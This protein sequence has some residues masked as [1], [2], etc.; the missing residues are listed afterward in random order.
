MD[1]TILDL[2]ERSV[3]LHH[4]KIAVKD[5]EYA[6]TY[7]QLQNMAMR[8]ASAL[9]TK[10]SGRVERYPIIIFIDK[11][12]KCLAAIL[13]VLYSGNAYVPVDIKTPKDRLS[14]I[15]QTLG[16]SA[17]AISL[18]SEVDI[19]NGFNLGI[20]TYDYDELLD[21]DIQSKEIIEE[22]LKKIRKKIVDTD[23][24]YIL[25]KNLWKVFIF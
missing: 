24:M 15:I 22:K 9:Y 2:F 1:N 20:T 21:A 16:G 13:G 6:Y 12:A 10:I 17:I 14:N 19:L 25:F 3:K 23:L 8:I 11:G 4:G 18:A 5:S 7:G